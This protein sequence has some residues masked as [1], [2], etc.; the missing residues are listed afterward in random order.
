M[1]CCRAKTATTRWAAAR[2]TTPSMAASAMTRGMA[3]AAAISLVGDEGS[4][5]CPATRR[6]H[7]RRRPIQRH[8]AR[9]AVRLRRPIIAKRS[10]A[11]G[12]RT[13]CSSANQVSAITYG[14]MRR[15]SVA[16]IRSRR[17]RRRYYRGRPRQCDHLRVELH[18]APATP[19]HT[20]AATVSMAPATTASPATSSPRLRWPTDRYFGDDDRSPAAP[21]T[22]QSQHRAGRRQ[23]MVAISATPGSPAAPHVAG[24]Q[25]RRPIRR[26]PVCGNIRAGSRY[27]SVLWLTPAMSSTAAADDTIAGDRRW[28]SRTAFP[29]PLLRRLCQHLRRQRRSSADRAPTC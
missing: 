18:K 1:T 25:R 13:T 16:A 5:L 6:G 23:P 7:G 4:A 29:T 17:R 10:I 26:R 21:A 14:F 2:A 9:L 22:T 19:T 12:F 3:T 27:R 28:P 24:R 15:S 20:A 8:A 11:G